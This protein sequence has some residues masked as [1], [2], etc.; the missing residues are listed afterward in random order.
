MKNFG[1]GNI[2]ATIDDGILYWL[3]FATTVTC[4]NNS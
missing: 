2:S 3:S 1:F 4:R